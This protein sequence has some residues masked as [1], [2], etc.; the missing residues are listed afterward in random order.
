MSWADLLTHHRATKHRV[1]CQGCYDGQ[2][3]IW[4]AGSE[5]YLTHLEEENVCRECEAHF[6]SP[7]NLHH[8]SKQLNFLDRS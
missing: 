8:V 1:V 3:R 5:E 7:S 4:V 2:G 6:T